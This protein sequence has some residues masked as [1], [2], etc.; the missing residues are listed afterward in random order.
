MKFGRKS[1]ATVVDIQY[2]ACN[3]QNIEELYSSLDSSDKAKY[4]CHFSCHGKP[5]FV[6]SYKF[7]PPDDAREEDII[8]KISAYTNVEEYLHIGDPLPI[9]YWIQKTKDVDWDHVVSMPFPYPINDPLY[10]TDILFA[11]SSLGNHARIRSKLL[12]ERKIKAA[13]R[14]NQRIQDGFMI[15]GP[16]D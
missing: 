6:I 14:E 1:I 13:L 8:H 4:Q 5:H 3:R 12:E 16:T 11:D 2:I 7:N 15:S 10:T 9:L